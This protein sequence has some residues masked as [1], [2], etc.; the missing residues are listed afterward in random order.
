MYYPIEISNGLNSHFTHIGPRLANNIPQSSDCFE[1][2]IMPSD[3][4]FTLRETHCG[5]VQR[6]ICSLQ[7]KKATGL[8]GISVRLLKE[9]V[10][11][12]VPSPTHIINLFIVSGYFPEKWKISIKSY[13]SNRSQSTYANGTLSDYLPI[14]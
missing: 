8:N 13:L 6:L 5:V 7:V 4:S 14:K 3:S 12:I 2:F 10:P 9:A 1:D 11:V